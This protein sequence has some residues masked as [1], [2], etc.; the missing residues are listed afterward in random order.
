MIDQSTFT[1]AQLSRFLATPGVTW[2]HDVD[3]DM[4][5]AMMMAAFERVTRVQATY[6]VRLRAPEY[7][8]F[9]PIVAQMVEWIALSGHRIGI[10]VD[11][12]LPRDATIG[13]DELDE[14]VEADYLMLRSAL[15]MV[16]RAVSFHAPPHHVLWRTV[17][18]FDHAMSLEWRGRYVA[19]SRGRFPVW[20]ES[21]D[22][23]LQANLHPEWWFLPL[24]RRDALHEREMKAP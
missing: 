21:F 24:D 16:E 18:G 8:V 10:H 1:T 13:Q 4:P 6:Y 22:G 3:Y 2:R 5:C 9:D 23:P 20:P 14:R 12:G 17:R 19:D 15:P 7:N 11:L